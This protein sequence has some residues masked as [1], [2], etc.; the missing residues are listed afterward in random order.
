MRM[1]ELISKITVSKDSK[2]AKKVYSSREDSIA[3]I[4]RKQ[5][6]ISCTVNGKVRKVKKNK[7]DN[8]IEAVDVTKAAVDILAVITKGAE[9]DA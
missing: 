2:L 3:Y 7:E 9:T 4:N 5:E 1:A 6:K 8:K